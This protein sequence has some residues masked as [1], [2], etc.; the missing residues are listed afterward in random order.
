MAPVPHEVRDKILKDVYDTCCLERRPTAA[1]ASVC[2][3]WQEFFEAKHFQKLTVTVPRLADFDRIVVG[4]R[5]Q[6][7]RHIW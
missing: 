5:R 6:L 4:E 7:V 2:S 1:Y 3:E